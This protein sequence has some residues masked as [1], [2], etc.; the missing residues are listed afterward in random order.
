M[1][2]V[3]AITAFSS[4]LHYG[5]HKEA[6]PTLMVIVPIVTI[7]SILFLFAI[8]SMGILLGGFIPTQAAAMALSFLMIFFPGFFLTGL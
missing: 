8:L 2:A 3:A 4:M 5:T 1:S 7:L 6:G